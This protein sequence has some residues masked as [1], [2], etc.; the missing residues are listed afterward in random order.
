[1]RYSHCVI[2]GPQAKR[3]HDPVLKNRQ[4]DANAVVANEGLPAV[5]ESNHAERGRL[6]RRVEK[7]EDD[8][9]EERGISIKGLLKKLIPGRR[10]K[11]ENKFRVNE[12]ARREWYKKEAANLGYELKH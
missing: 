10:Y 4:P 9:D 8:S 2:H 3:K 12:I 11:V 6:L 1:M 7:Y 5:V